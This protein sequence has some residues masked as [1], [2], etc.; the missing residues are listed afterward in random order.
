MCHQ[1][2]CPSC[3]LLPTAITTCPCGVTPISLLL[4]GGEERVSCFDPI[5]TCNKVCE[6]KLPCS[7]TGKLIRIIIWKCLQSECTISLFLI[8]DDP[9]LCSSLCHL[10]ECSSCDKTTTVKCVCGTSSTSVPCVEVVDG[11]W[12]EFRCGRVCNKK[13][14]CG[15]H[16]CNT[17][18]CVVSFI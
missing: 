11:K 14:N 9:H 4:A 1:G 13:K 8:L 3:P 10:G 6:K 16:R 12:E 2:V 15:R 5:P 18:C 17:R 7:T